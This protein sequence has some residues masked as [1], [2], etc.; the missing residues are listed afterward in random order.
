MSYFPDDIARERSSGE[1]RGT[2]VD[3]R[4]ARDTGDDDG[5]SFT[6]TI[7]P[8]RVFEKRAGIAA[9]V[10]ALGFLTLSSEFAMG[11]RAFGSRGV[12]L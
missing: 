7:S 8:L 1:G 10:D 5:S 12:P 2:K 11:A 9:L 4:F 6:S 3:C